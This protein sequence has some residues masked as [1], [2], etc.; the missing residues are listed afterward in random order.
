MKTE[1]LTQEEME[2]ELYFEAKFHSW[3]LNGVTSVR[4]LR[5]K[6]KKELRNTRNP[7]YKR[8]MVKLSY[9]D[10]LADHFVNQ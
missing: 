1:P 7:E 9:D 10:A 4:Q 5:R 3:L 2:L 6:I 8:F